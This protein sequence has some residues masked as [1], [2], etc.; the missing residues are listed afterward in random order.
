VCAWRRGESRGAACRRLQYSS[1]HCLGPVAR[2]G[3][4][5]STHGRKMSRASVHQDPIVLQRARG[6]ERA[7]RACRRMWSVDCQP[8]HVRPDGASQTCSRRVP[9]RRPRGWRPGAV[10]ADSMLKLMRRPPPS[11]LYLLP[12]RRLVC[13]EPATWCTESH[14]RMTRNFQRWPLLPLAA[15]A[16]SSTGAPM[17][18]LGLWYPYSSDLSRTAT[19][20]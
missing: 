11:P 16:A 8:E 2:K 4:A 20:Q 7:L 19:K 17:E 13:T 10:G 9:F 6:S 3:R 15:T 1:L 14:E 12:L 18:R 5:G